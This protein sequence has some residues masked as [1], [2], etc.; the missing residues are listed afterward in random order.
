MVDRSVRSILKA[1]KWIA[2]WSIAITALAQTTAPSPQAAAAPAEGFKVEETLLGWWDLSMWTSVLP[3]VS[4]DGRHVAMVARTRGC[5]KGMHDCLAV[6]G[7]WSPL[8][9]QSGW[10]LALSPDGKR[11][12]YAANNGKKW[13]VVVDGQAGPEFDGSKYSLPPGLS[14]S[15]DGKRLVCEIKRDKQ[16]ST[17]VDGQRI[18]LEYDE[19]FGLSFSPDGKRMAY[20]A[21]K[22]G[23]SFAVVDDRPGAGYDEIQGLTFSPDSRRFAYGARQGAKWLVVADGQ[24]SMAYDPP[25]ILGSMAPGLPTSWHSVGLQPR[26]SSDSEHVIFV[27]MSGGKWVVVVDGQWTAVA[28]GTEDKG[29]RSVVVGGQVVPECD[30]NRINYP[31]VSPDGKR[32]AFEVVPNWVVVDGQASP[33]FFEVFSPRFS[34]DGAHV[35]YVGKYSG[36]GLLNSLRYEWILVVDGQPYPGYLGFGDWTFSQDGKHL[37]YAV[38]THGIAPGVMDLGNLPGGIGWSVLLDHRAGPE[39][40]RILSN[41]LNFDPDGTLT[42]L[43][44]RRG[45]RSSEEKKS[46][47]IGTEHGSLYRVKYIP[48]P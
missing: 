42:F 14:F 19:A 34:P 45:H 5:P 47:L 48:A 28:Y 32:M 40:S 35:A 18:G 41:T 15:P 39:Y 24:A 33:K 16:R 26:F 13:V 25:E 21:R 44:I 46:E 36:K 29:K 17:V 22:G 8:L 12:A 31:A 6:D 38:Q 3:V 9:V 43:A 7:Q 10:S 2:L 4:A 30:G 23:Q 37:A 20:L 1:A 11:V 27:A